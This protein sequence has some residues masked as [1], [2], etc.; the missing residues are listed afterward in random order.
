[1]LGPSYC[2]EHTKTMLQ[3]LRGQASILMIMLGYDL[4]GM[5]LSIAVQANQS[6]QMLDNMKC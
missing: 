6:P 4:F 2:L 5:A 1:M 3:E